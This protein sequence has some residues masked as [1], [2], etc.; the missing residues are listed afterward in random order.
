MPRLIRSFTEV[1]AP[2]AQP[3]ETLAGYGVGDGVWLLYSDGYSHPRKARVIAVLP[4][5]H[6]LVLR[7]EQPDA[8]ISV[9]PIFNPHFLRPMEAR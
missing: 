8:I 7:A 4:R 2:P 1:L 3:R 6:K 5:Q 9:N